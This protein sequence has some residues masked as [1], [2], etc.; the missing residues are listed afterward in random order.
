M[1]FEILTS[2][3]NVLVLLFLWW[4]MKCFS[5]HSNWLSSDL[6]TLFSS[7]F[8]RLERRNLFKL[9]LIDEFSDPVWLLQSD[10]LFNSELVFKSFSLFLLIII[11]ACTCTDSRT[12]FF[13]I[14]SRCLKEG[15]LIFEVHSEIDTF[16][17]VF[18]HLFLFLILCPW[19]G[20]RNLLNIWINFKKYINDLQSQCWCKWRWWWKRFIYLTRYIFR[21]F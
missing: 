21:P 8:R 5:F 17:L 10:F 12:F 18:F 11:T 9:L 1:T 20:Q 19:C 14:F 4:S 6:S 15:N 16:E 13:N 2:I 3:S 7:H